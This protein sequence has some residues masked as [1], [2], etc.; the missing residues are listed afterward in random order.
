MRSINTN[1]IVYEILIE[2]TAITKEHT[3]LTPC[4]SGVEQSTCSAYLWPF[5]V[6]HNKIDYPLSEKQ[7]DFEKV[8]I[9]MH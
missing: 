3:R 1:I 9:K 5:L 4:I 6:E 2:H 7:H 8:G